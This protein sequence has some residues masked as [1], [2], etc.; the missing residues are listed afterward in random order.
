L[1]GFQ[2]LKENILQ[3]K[4]FKRNQEKKVWDMVVKKDKELKE[5]YVQLQQVQHLYSKLQIMK[6]IPA[7]IAPKQCLMSDQSKHHLPQHHGLSLDCHGV[8]GHQP[9]AGR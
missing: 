1:S 3:E 8:C 7:L 5:L 4:D 9:E 6:K 2:S